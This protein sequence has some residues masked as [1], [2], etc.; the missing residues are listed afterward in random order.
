MQTFPINLRLE[1]LPVLMIG[2]GAIAAEKLEKLVPHRPVL[3]LV[4]P[5][6]VHATEALVAAHGVRWIRGDYAP[7]H[8]DG[9][10][11][12][13][14]AT[15]DVALSRRI[16]ADARSR[17]VL[18]N[19]VDLPECCDFI[20]PAVVAGAHFSIAI[21]TGGTA[22]GYARQ[23]REQLQA[24]V[25]Q[26]DGILEVLEQIR[27]NL[28]RKGNTFAARRERLWEILHELEDLERDGGA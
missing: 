1:G 12:V 19:A 28:K 13:F 21:S 25:R 4:S 7:A 16:F 9:Q 20:M 8:L 22:A 11:L 14:A 10:R 24:V 5:R 15:G 3:T 6:L 23:L 26:E 2:G 17:A 18:V 27:A